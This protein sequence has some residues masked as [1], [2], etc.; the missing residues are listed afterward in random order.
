M[1]TNEFEGSRI[2]EGTM[3]TG[4][5]HVAIPVDIPP[6]G[7]VH[8]TEA[9]SGAEAVAAANHLSTQPHPQPEKT[10]SDQSE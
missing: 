5:Y 2:S 4:A 7:S 6:A 10:D 1:K 8:D 3:R 9:E